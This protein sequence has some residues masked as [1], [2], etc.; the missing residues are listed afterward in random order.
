MSS[1]QLS[2]ETEEIISKLKF[3]PDETNEQ[4]IERIVHRAQEYEFDVILTEQDLADIKLE[5]KMIDEGN[6]V[7][8][9]Q[10]I[11]SDKT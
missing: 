11:A 7:T 6:F 3:S 5:S 1:I 9:E 2:K 4:C 8:L 10:M